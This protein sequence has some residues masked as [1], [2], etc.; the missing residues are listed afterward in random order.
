MAD[1]GRTGAL[2]PVAELEPVALSGT[3]V[4]RASLHNLDYI[5]SRDVRVG[6]SVIVE[7][8]GELIPQVIEVNL[9][10]RPEG[11]EAW[12]APTHCPAC[13]TPVRRIEGEAALRCPN[14]GCPGR[15]EAAVFHF[16]RR[17]A[18]DIDGL[19]HSLIEQLVTSGLIR[20]LADIFALPA[21][22]EDLLE[23]DRMAKK[24]ADSLVASIDRARTT[25]GFDRL[26]SGLGI[27]LVGSVAARVL[28]EKYGDL[29]SLLHRAPADL[30]TDLDAIS[31]VGPKIA[32]SVAAFLA[33]P[34]QRNVLEKLLSFG[35]VAQSVRKERTSGPL[36]GLSFCVTGTLSKPREEIHAQIHA[37]GGE[38]HTGVK[39]GTTYLVVGDK[40]GQTKLEAARK[41]GAQILDEAAFEALLSG[42]Q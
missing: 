11:T 2:T 10:Q 36:N 26:L 33:S 15:L 34:D 41:K 14:L 4:S 31:G 37:L 19:G 25:R 21:R 17:S 13:N 39:T 29:R 8:A 6:D 5:A 27:P 16:T 7:K 24:S 38:T 23:L 28:A 12:S 42:G 9:A 32:E 20:D 1:V 40:V 3:V 22:V 35:V 30:R 18:M